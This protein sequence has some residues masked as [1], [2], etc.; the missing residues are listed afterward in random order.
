MAWA[1]RGRSLRGLSRGE[2]R[3]RNSVLPAIVAGA[4]LACP[5]AAQGALEDRDSRTGR[6]AVSAE[7]KRL[8]ERVSTSARWNRFGTPQSL[9]RHGGFIARGLRGRNAAA[10][11]KNWLRANRAKPVLRRSGEELAS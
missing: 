4:V 9:I 6:T 5:A 10:A 1:R 8:A 11:A 3:M 7:Q 2:S